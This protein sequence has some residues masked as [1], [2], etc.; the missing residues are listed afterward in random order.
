MMTYLLPV[1]LVAG[2]GLIAGLGLAIASVLMAVPVNQKAVDLR[3]ALPGNNCGACG[4][5]GCDAYAEALA[6]GVKDTGLCTPG[7]AQVAQDLADILGV[8]AGSVVRSSAL[9][10]C[11]GT[12]DCAKISY[13]YQGVDNCRMA[14]QLSGG[15]MA[16]KA[17]CIGLGDCVRAC[18]YEAIRICNGVAVVSPERCKSCRLCVA[19]CPKGLIQIVSLERKRAQVVCQSKEKG[20]VT[21]KECSAGCIG[22]MKCAKAC[23]E[24]AIQVTDNLARVDAKQCTGC[25][26]CVDVCP[27]GCIILRG[28]EGDG[29]SHSAS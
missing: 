3:E 24:G 19:A 1:L 27:S 10:R 14:A 23:P 13:D 29:T 9:V 15:P 18:P 17:G 12:A 6:S 25:G 7:G 2:I 26:A 20:G 5:S 11:R 8:E 4:Y 16:C 28:G 21:R 22:C